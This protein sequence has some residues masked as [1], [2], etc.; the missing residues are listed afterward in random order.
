MPSR[1]GNCPGEEAQNPRRTI[2]LAICFCLL[3]VFFAYSGIAAVLTLMWPYYLQV[4]STTHYYLT[5]T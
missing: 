3:I 1:G 5:T 2:P 4:T